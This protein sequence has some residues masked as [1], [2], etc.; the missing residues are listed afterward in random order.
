M[1]T[2][3]KDSIRLRRITEKLESSKLPFTTGGKEYRADA[4]S[5]MGGIT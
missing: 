4:N 3:N 5:A 2:H 1:K